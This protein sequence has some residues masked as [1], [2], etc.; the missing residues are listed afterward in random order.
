MGHSIFISHGGPDSAI[1]LKVADELRGSG[2][3]VALDREQLRQGDVFLQFM[4]KSL[5]EC[6]YCLLLWSAAAAKGKW[7]A[8]EWEAALYR[9]IQESRRF[10][11]IGCLDQQPLPALLAPRLRT[12]LYPALY[13]GLAELLA[14][15]S[16]D[17]AAEEVSSRPIANAKVLVT[18]DESGTTVYVTS[19]LFGITQPLKLDL[20]VPSGVHLD[21]LIANFGLPKQQDHQGVMGVTYEYRLVHDDVALARSVSLAS[22]G[23]EKGAVLWLEVEIKPFARGAPVTGQ[24]SGARFRGE[25]AA[26]GDTVRARKSLLE[27]IQAA[28]LGA[29]FRA[30]L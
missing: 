8:V 13:P 30:A 23:V 15:F 20:E 2:L 26:G 28:G 6:T 29:R 9:A 3:E 5:S 25:S 14:L 18:D 21:R 19:E 11:M 27:A 1:A 10:L 16:E 24:L 4:E 17:L 7:V 22:Q 12:T